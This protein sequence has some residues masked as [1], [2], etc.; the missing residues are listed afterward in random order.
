MGNDLVR[1][2][3]TTEMTRI[4][5][6]GVAALAKK[7]AMNRLYKQLQGATWGNIKGTSLTP[8][9]L[10]AMAAFCVKTG[11]EP[12][13][14]VDVLGGRPYLNAEYYRELA[15]THPRYVD[16]EQTNITSDKAKREEWGVPEEAKAAW[17]TTIRYFVQ[18][19]PLEAIKAG[20]IPVDDAQQ[21]IK[22]ATECN[23]AGTLSGA[24]NKDPVGDSH[25]HKT[26]RSR[27]FR[28]T[29]KLA[30]AAWMEEQ[31]DAVDRATHFMEAEWEEIQE[32][33][34]AV[35]TPQHVSVGTGEPRAAI[36]APKEAEAPQDDP[37]LLTD[38]RKR[39]YA[40]LGELKLKKD[41]LRKPWQERNG[42]PASVT[43][44]TLADYERADQLLLGPVRKKVAELCA[45]TDTD[46][47]GLSN[48]LWNQ[49]APD[50]AKQWLQA[51]KTL[52]GKAKQDEPEP[53]LVGQGRMTL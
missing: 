38:A 19:A 1:T 27:S 17:L 43:Q 7:E 35:E 47:E 9:T 24:R 52:E 40:T 21:W 10:A 49:A 30:F 12:Q 8:Q 16:A 3:A 53:E 45:A 13:T 46:L 4:Q 36:G 6:A 5:E 25:P 41:E 42:L 11:A 23:H 2:S 18:M 48:M 29:A 44:F 50:Y 22:C 14:H 32:E 26:A 39:Y 28:R 20:R 37:A 33:N 15:T 34:A 31:Q 51:M